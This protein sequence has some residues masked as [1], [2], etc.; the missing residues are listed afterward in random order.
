[1][2]AVSTEPTSI[3]PMPS[4][5]VVGSSGLPMFHVDDVMNESPKSAKISKPRYSR[6]AAIR[7]S[8]TNENNAAVATNPLNTRSTL[9]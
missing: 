3:A 9:V 8:I 6:N 2:N 1:M 7:I 5:A 4:T